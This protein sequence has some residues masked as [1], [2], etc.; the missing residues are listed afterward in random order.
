MAYHLKPGE[1]VPQGLRRI[2]AEQL[3]KAIEHLQS[4]AGARERTRKRSSAR[5]S[6]SR[7]DARTVGSSSAACS[8]PPPF[9]RSFPSRSALPCGLASNIFLM[10]SVSVYNRLKGYV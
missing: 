6:R 3:G 8:R 7:S 2:A 5:H 9:P 4:T 10:S 1:S